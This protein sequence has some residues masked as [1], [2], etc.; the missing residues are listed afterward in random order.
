MSPG[1]Y[2]QIQEAVNAAASGDRILLAPGTYREE[3]RM[4]GKAVTLDEPIRILDKTIERNEIG[5][6]VS[7]NV[8][9][10]GNQISDNRY[11]GILSRG[12]DQAVIA[13]RFTANGLDSAGLII[14]WSRNSKIPI[15]EGSDE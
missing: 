14:D 3:I 2:G 9:V 12:T 4:S 7:G 15:K 6:S 1:E 11:I 8:L 5:L 10:E 13:N